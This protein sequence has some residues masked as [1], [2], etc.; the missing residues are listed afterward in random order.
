M[1]RSQSNEVLTTGDVARICHVA[2]RTVSKWF[3]TGK[4]R[5]Y[6][7]P[8]SRDRRIPRSQLLAFMRAHGMPT[9]EI[10][11]A[12]RG[13]L[14]YLDDRANGL[15]GRLADLSRFEVREA[16][17]PFEVGLNLARMR[18]DM[19]LI[20]ASLDSDELQN[21]CR[22]VQDDEELQVTRIIGVVHG[23]E[24][25]ARHHLAE[26]RIRDVVDASQQTEDLEAS[27]LQIA[28][29]PSQTY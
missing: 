20:G 11:P 14:A 19:L 5:G 24:D 7:I 15:A 4:L 23:P 17:C 21:L 2:P 1:A 18:P 25:P 27:L 3:D 26:T 28:V 29:S 12:K 8:G 10:E 16:R 13:L 22:L 9:E 6:R